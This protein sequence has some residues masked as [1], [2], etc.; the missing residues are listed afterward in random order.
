[1]M[2][3]GCEGPAAQVLTCTSKPRPWTRMAAMTLRER[4]VQRV[5][6]SIKACS[7]PL[8]SNGAYKGEDTQITIV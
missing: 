3:P 8:R 4:P 5:G 1:M 7:A 6:V 2:M